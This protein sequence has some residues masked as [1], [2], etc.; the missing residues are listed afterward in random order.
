MNVVEMKGM[1]NFLRL[2]LERTYYSKASRNVSS[3]IINV[4]FNPDTNEINGNVFAAMIY[5][6]LTPQEK[7]KSTVFKG[8]PHGEEV[9]LHKCVMQAN[10]V[11]SFSL[12]E[13]TEMEYLRVVV[14]SR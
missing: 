13:L 2:K 11:R 1:D 3:K 10:P 9:V 14:F 7:V 6:G 12:Q 4:P 5:E 8:Y